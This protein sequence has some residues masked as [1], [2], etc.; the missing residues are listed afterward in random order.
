MEDTFY[1]R[2]EN[3][4]VKIRA[5]ELK[6]F[7]ESFDRYEEYLKIKEEFLQEKKDQIRFSKRS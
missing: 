5:F 3:I 6:E 7:Y 2:D 4:L 1:Y